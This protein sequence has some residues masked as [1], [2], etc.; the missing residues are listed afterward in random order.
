MIKKICK[1]IIISISFI[2]FALLM[3][4]LINSE[5]RRKAFNYPAGIINIYYQTK[6]LTAVMNKNFEQTS[7]ILNQYINISQ[8]LSVGKNKLMVG[9]FKQ[10]KYA[11]DKALTQEDFNF[12]EKIYIKIYNIDDKIYLNNVWLGRAF[13]DNDLNLAQYHLKKAIKLSPSSEEAYRVILKM[14]LENI[15]K[16]LDPH[17]A[18]EYCNNYFNSIIGGTSDLIF[19][20]FFDGNKKDFAIYI[21]Q[22]VKNIYKQKINKLN[23]FISYQFNFDEKKDVL[24]I[25]IIG[26]FIKGSIITIKD[27]SLNNFENSKIETKE[28]YLI[29]TNNYL[30]DN[31]N[32]ELVIL[33]INEKNNL[34]RLLLNENKNVESLTFSMK[35]NKIPI[36]YN[37]FCKKFL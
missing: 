13:L 6:I 16:N 19:G 34:I 9:V 30:L 22:E 26:T 31:N 28:I 4:L 32:D 14:Y 21:N 35:I 10:L 8:E 36:T 12:L 20:N 11:S 5:F 37:N 29:S 7:D 1:Y 25:N 17:L 33:N 2:F 24:S 18:S 15:N 23:E 3:I 27:I